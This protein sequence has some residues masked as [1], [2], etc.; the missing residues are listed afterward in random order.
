MSDEVKYQCPECKLHYAE[1]HHAEACEQ[2]CRQYRACSLEITKHSI[3]ANETA[4]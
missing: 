4:I 3:E 2:F 1:K